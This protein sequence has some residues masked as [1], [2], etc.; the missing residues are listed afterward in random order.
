[1]D[2]CWLTDVTYI[3]YRSAG[4]VCPRRGREAGRAV[5]DAVPRVPHV[6]ASET[7]A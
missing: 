4:S 3:Y 5:D 1:M 6:P 7:A 2:V